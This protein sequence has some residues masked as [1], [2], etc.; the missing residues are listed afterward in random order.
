MNT[1]TFP[2]ETLPM[3]VLDFIVLTVTLLF[4]T[5]ILGLDLAYIAVAIGG[6]LSGAVMLAYFRRD[7]RKTEQAFKTLCA[8]IG[9]VILGSTLE[10]FAKVTQ[11]KYLLGIYFFSG[12]LSLAILRGLLNLTERNSAELC[13]MVLQRIFNLRLPEENER[14]RKRIRRTVH[15]SLLPEQ[16]DEKKDGE[17]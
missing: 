11:P 12:L 15:T 1:S 17:K 4:N 14:P 16:S 2:N 13:R 6:S 10:E 7:P 8:A 3:K 9:G 5:L